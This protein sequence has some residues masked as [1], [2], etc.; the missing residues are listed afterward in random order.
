MS[1]VKLRCPQPRALGPFRA[2]G[3]ALRQLSP[4][5]PKPE[6]L[7]ALS[8]ENVFVNVMPYSWDVLDLDFAIKQH[9]AAG[10]KRDSINR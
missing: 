3:T 9:S 2:G 1:W 6:A 4:S 5:L 10:E 8:F 7:A